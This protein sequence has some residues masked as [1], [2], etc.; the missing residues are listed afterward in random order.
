[1]KRT[2]EEVR[3]YYRDEARA[4][5]Y[6]GD[7]FRQPL[8]A[9]L[10]DRQVSQ[11]IK[12]LRGASASSVLEIAGGPARLTREIAAPNEW[13]GTMIDASIPMLSVAQVDFAVPTAIHGG[14]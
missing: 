7:R 11:V 10:H 3:T 13:T 9:L 6:V 12:T 5:E 14:W 8:G 1:M 4:Q 2:E